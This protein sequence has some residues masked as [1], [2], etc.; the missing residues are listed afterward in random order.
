MLEHGKET[1]EAGVTEDT[2]RQY[3]IETHGYSFKEPDEINKFKRLFHDVF[4]DPLGRNGQGGNKLF[5]DMDAYFKLLEYVELTEARKSATTATRFASIAIV[6]SILSMGA[7]I[8]F[9]K[10]QLDTPTKIDESQFE[11]IKQLKFDSSLIEK[12]LTQLSEA[13][14]NQ[15]ELIEKS[16]NNT[17]KRD[18][19]DA[20][21]LKAP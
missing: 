6:I 19:Q 8:Y 3:F 14:D 21:R 13:H 5:M 15:V 9:S 4:S 1:L 16:Y 11:L 20:T 12:K 10:L 2:V 7:S 18:L 17:L